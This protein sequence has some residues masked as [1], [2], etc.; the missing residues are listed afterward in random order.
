MPM[1]LTH[2]HSI[3]A[4]LPRGGIGAEI[5]VAHGLFSVDILRLSEPSLLYLIDC[6]EQLP[7][8]VTG[9]DPANSGDE[10]KEGWYRATFQRFIDDSRVR[11]IKAF[12]QKA[13]TLFPDAY[14]DWLYLDA[15]HL[16]AYQDAWAWWPKV[17]PGGWMMGHDYVDVG[18]CFTVKTDVDRFAAEIS[19][20]V[21]VTVDADTAYKN[22]LIQKPIAAES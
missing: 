6:W 5:G 12:S 17:K 7:V 1:D 8:E 2:R 3:F 18:D 22:W 11:V 10:V 20:P 4:S 13:A 19:Q 21:L 14:F 15:N 9:H 16:E